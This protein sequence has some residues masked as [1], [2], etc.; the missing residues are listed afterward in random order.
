[1]GDPAVAGLSGLGDRARSRAAARGGTRQVTVMIPKNIGMNLGIATI[2]R[3]L[4]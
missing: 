1:M 2:F 4:P 3:A